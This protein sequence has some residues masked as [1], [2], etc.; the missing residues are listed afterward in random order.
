M[1]ASPASS[2]AAPTLTQF[3][4]EVFVP[5]TDSVRANRL[6]LDAEAAARRM[7]EEGIPV[8]YARSIFVPDEETCFILYQAAT[9]DDVVDAAE[10]AGVPLER[11]PVTVVEWRVD[12]ATKPAR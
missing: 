11:R 1:H 6:A 7:Q 9:V 10:R 2:P 3:L 4:V 8:R 5:R 12:D